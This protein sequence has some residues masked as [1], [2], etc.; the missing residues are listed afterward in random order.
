MTNAGGHALGAAA[1]GIGVGGLE[2]RQEAGGAGGEDALAVGGTTDAGDPG[3]GG[4]SGELGKRGQGARGGERSG[5]GGIAE[6]GEELRE[7]AVPEVVEAGALGRREFADAHVVT[8]EL[9]ERV[10][11]AGAGEAALGELALVGQ[12]ADEIGITRIGMLRVEARDLAFLLDGEGV[13]EHVVEP[14][15]FAGFGRKAPV[16]AGRLEGDDDAGEAV[17]LRQGARLGEE[18][19]NGFGAGTE[20]AAA[21]DVGA[22]AVAGG[23]VLAGEIEAQDEGVRRDAL[24]LALAL[25]LRTSQAA[26]DQRTGA[27]E[28]SIFHGA[29]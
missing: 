1:Y 16:M 8:G 19:V 9:P 10:A 20:A 24:A 29:G 26:A 6:D 12:R 25:F 5:A 14:R 11:L 23:L 7:R 22:V 28:R 2:K 4:E 21:E 13:D 15:A 17:G 18:L 27:G 3:A